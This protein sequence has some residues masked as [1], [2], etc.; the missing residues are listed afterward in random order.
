[1]KRFATYSILGLAVLFFGVA[2]RGDDD[3]RD[4]RGRDDSRVAKGFEISPV[5]V[6]ATKRDRELVGLG[7]YIVNAQA[8][9]TTATR[10]RRTR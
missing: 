10:V 1:M 5:P 7:S 8:G 4:D 9:A 6:H 3:R 2:A